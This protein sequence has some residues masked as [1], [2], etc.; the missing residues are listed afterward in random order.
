MFKIAS[1]VGIKEGGLWNK[2]KGD[3]GFSFSFGDEVD[4]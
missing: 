2:L 3:K 4:D 1:N